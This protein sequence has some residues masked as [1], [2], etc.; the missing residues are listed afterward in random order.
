MSWFFLCIGGACGAVTRYKI[1]EFLLRHAKDGFPLGALCIN[2]S[3]AMLLGVISGLDFTGSP[4]LLMGDGFCGAFTTFSTF[5]VESVKLLKS[6]NIKKS[7]LFIGAS[8]ILG[9]TLFLSGYTAGKL[10][11][12]AW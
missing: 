3:G 12:G 4:Y 5:S 8:V 7:T 11:T 10:F 2:V 6:G 1:G 9:L